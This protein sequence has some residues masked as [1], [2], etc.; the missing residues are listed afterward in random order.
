MVGRAV[1]ES[2]RVQRDRLLHFSLLQC[3]VAAPPQLRPPPPKQSATRER[4]EC[5]TPTDLHRLQGYTGVQRGARRW[6]VA[7]GAACIRRRP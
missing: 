1:G 3:R 2:V 4:F 5:L 7:V 6:L